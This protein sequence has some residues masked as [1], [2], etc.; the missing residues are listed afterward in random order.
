MSEK[1]N[2]NYPEPKATSSNRFFYE[3]TNSFSFDQ[4]ID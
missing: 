3:K 1:V 2:R 4:L